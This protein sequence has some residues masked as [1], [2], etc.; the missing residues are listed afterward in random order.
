MTGLN[1]G[2]LAQTQDA[3]KFS[4]LHRSAQGRP[5]AT[6]LQLSSASTGVGTDTS[7]WGFPGWGHSGPWA[8]I[9]WQGLSRECVQG[10]GFLGPLSEALWRLSSGMFLNRP[11]GASFG[12]AG[13]EAALG[14]SL[15]AQPLLLGLSSHSYLVVFTCTPPSGLPLQLSLDH[16]QNYCR[17]RD[18]CLRDQVLCQKPCFRQARRSPSCSD[19]PSP[20]E[21]ALGCC[22]CC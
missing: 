7:R 1:C 22:C 10:L 9:T 11:P 12:C 18:L 20:R 15:G 6:S 3:F 17:C 8:L 21:R 19:L 16:I 2:P 4:S 14:T 13:V 5:E